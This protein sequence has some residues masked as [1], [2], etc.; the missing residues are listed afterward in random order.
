MVSLVVSCSDKRGALNNLIKVKICGVTNTEDAWAS[1]GAGCDAI[2][3]VFYKKSPRY[4]SPQK[5]MVIARHIGSRIIK[6]GVFVNAKE[7]TIRRIAKMC[8]LDLLQFHGDET[9]D[10]CRKFKD[11]KIVKAFR[12]NAKI[13]FKN[14]LRYKTF[15][16]LF[17]AF[18]KARPGG[19]AKK[20]N[21]R[22]LSGCKGVFKRPI[23]LSGGLNKYNLRK[24]IEIVRPDW[25]DVSS[26]VEIRPGEKDCKKIKEFIR[27]ARN[28][29]A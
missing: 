6:V 9:V 25:I 29:R 22:L 16:Y 11:Y 4:I 3:F 17:D 10:F 14:I 8:K 28:L 27:I 26:S 21:W 7:R 12:V 1:V 2:G 15:A 20:F 5:A 13:D 18:D 19:T 24:A 23:F